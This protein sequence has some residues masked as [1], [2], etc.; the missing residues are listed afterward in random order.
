VGTRAQCVGRG[1]SARDGAR[2][3]RTVRSISEETA[4]DRTSAGDEATTVT[5]GTS[6]VRATGRGRSA[7]PR[8]VARPVDSRS[9]PE[10]AALDSTLA[11]DQTT[12]VTKVRGF[13]LCGTTGNPLAGVPVAL[14]AEVDEGIERPLGL[15]T[16]D[17]AG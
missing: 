9:V 1:E 4:L 14:W 3:W 6:G 8:P 5:R 2:P 15:L 17:G 16:S 12:T 7:S 11:T 10:E 13:V